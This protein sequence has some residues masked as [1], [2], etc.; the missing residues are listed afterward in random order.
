M[1]LATS[2]AKRRLSK[3]LRAPDPGTPK[4]REQQLGEIDNLLVEIKEAEQRPVWRAQDACKD[5]ARTNWAMSSPRVSTSQSRRR[6]RG[7]PSQPQ[8]R[9]AR[10]P[11]RPTAPRRSRGNHPRQRAPLY[12]QAHRDPLR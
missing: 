11:L 10:H 9:G 12:R 5:E 6:G 8:L 1:A 7:E 4:G 3:L 2:D